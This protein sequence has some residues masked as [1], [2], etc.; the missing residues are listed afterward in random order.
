MKPSVG[1]GGRRTNA[2]SD[3]FEAFVLDWLEIIGVARSYFLLIE[4]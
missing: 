1:L 4:T 3:Q 2:I